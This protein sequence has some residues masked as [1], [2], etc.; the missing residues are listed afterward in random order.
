M[1]KPA[2]LFFPLLTVLLGGAPDVSGEWGRPPSALAPVPAAQ[3]IKDDFGR[4]FPLPERTPERIVSLA[5]NVTEILF[6]LGLGGRVV[7]VTRFCDYPPGTAAIPKI[8]GLVDPNI[9]VVQSLDPGLVVAFRG[10]PLRLVERMAKLGL[11]VFVCDVGEGL[12][13][14]FPLIERI[15]RITRT[16]DRARKVC[17][18]RL[19]ASR[20]REISESMVQYDLKLE[21]LKRELLTRD[22]KDAYRRGLVMLSGEKTVFSPFMKG[23]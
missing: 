11:P 22:E 12:G 18:L 1:R 9:E 10:N 5:P 21:Q 4:A 7:G 20:L 3:V 6:A 15:G 14:L 17:L 19:A 2:I 8:G 16:E 23:I 13:A